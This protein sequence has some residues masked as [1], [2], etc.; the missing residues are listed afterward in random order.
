[1]TKNE[2]GEKREPQEIDDETGLYVISVASELSPV[3]RSM[4]SPGMMSR[5][6]LFSHQEHV[7]LQTSASDDCTISPLFLD[8]TPFKREKPVANV[9]GNW[10]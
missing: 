6:S 2:N 10:E 1:M 4:S 3:K 8:S 7:S 5:R 9:E